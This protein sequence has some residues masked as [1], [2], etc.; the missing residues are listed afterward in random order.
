MSELTQEFEGERL[1]EWEEWYLKRKP[2][3]SLISS[4]SLGVKIGGS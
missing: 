2:D 4:I 3:V 1:R